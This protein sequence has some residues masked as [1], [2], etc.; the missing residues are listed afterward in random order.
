ME[1]VILAAG[2][3]SRLGRE[4]PKPLTELADGRTIMQQQ[5]DNVHAVFGPKI[6]I[7]IVVGYKLEQ[8]IEAHPNH[9]FIY[10]ES[11]GTT[12]TSKSLL[13]AF[14][15]L[16][17]KSDVFWLNGDVVFDFGILLKMQKFIDSKQSTVT[18]NN[19]KV[20]DEE[21]KYTLDKDG[22]IDSLSKKVSTDFALGE[23]V[24]INFVTAKDKEV[25]AYNLKKV[26]DDD[27]FEKA[28]ELS[29][30]A[31]IKFLPLNISKSSLNATEVDFQEDLEK[32]NQAIK[33]F[34]I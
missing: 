34:L 30:R 13:R 32:V 33:A 29:I 9:N 23:A 15:A 2:L 8:V 6:R 24:G 28:I 25:L 17:L 5:I 18:V 7:N 11:Y 4:I 1:V 12:N 3:G 14:S 10:N 21:V 19:N 27:Y 26:A 22:Y 31:G 20:S 16:P